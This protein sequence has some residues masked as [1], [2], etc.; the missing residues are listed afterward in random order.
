MNISRDLDLFK[1]AFT[2]RRPPILLNVSHSRFT[3]FNPD[4]FQTNFI[5]IYPRP[6]SLLT[7]IISP[8]RLHHTQGSTTKVSFAPVIQKRIKRLEKKIPLQHLLFL[9][10][11]FVVKRE[12]EFGKVFW[13]RISATTARLS[14][15]AKI[16]LK[17]EEV[18][19]SVLLIKHHCWRIRI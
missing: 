8:Q 15:F 14:F 1:V 4:A 10:S 19:C 16:I 6:E 11:V 3:N 7:F 2:K 9:V 13:L 5:T 17:K 18:S 12:T